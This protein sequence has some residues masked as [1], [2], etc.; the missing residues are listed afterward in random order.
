MD[1]KPIQI[2][3]PKF[4]GGD[5]PFYVRATDN[6]IFKAYV[7]SWC[8][9]L[10]SSGYSQVKYCIEFYDP[11]VSEYEEATEWDVSEERLFANELDAT[12]CKL[13]SLEKRYEAT[14]SHM[15]EMDSEMSEIRAR[16]NHLETSEKTND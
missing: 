12:L 3:T 8:I 1:Q 5:R 16:I 7:C 15:R 14:K 11:E 13:K 4:K 9:E 2:P 6:E 10:H